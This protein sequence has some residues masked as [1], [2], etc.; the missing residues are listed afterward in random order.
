MTT[1]I[2]GSSP[3]VTFSDGTTQTTAFTTGAVTQSTIATNVAGTGPLFRVWANAAQSITNGATVLIQNN[4]EIYDVGGCFNN[5]GSS[6]TLNGIT[7]PAYSFTP[8]VAGYYWV[9]GIVFAGATS[10]S[11]QTNIYMN[12]GTVIC[13]SSTINSNGVGAQVGLVT[14][15]NGTGD[16]VQIAGYNA[17]GGTINTLSGRSDLNIFEGFMIRSA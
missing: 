3:S 5:T 15:L 16:Y 14:Y 8:N 7:A 2:N 9:S 1:I 12:G 17:T 10:G 4:T 13:A 6:V 11:L